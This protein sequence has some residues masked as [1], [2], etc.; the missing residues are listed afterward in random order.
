MQV[1]AEGRAAAAAV[2]SPSEACGALARQPNRRSLESFEGRR[3]QVSE[4][5]DATRR[6]GLSADPWSPVALGALFFLLYLATLC[7]GI[8]W[9]DSA[10]FVTA[11]VTLGIPH[12][13]GYPL[14]TLLAHAF[15]WLP[16]APALAV[17]GMSAVGGGLSVALLHCVIR[18]L[19]ASNGA[20][21]IGA[22]TLGASALFW[23]QA[24]IAEAYTPGLAM[25]LGAWLLLVRAVEEDRTGFAVAAAGLAGLGLGVHLG[26][27]TCG[28]GFV[29]L[30]LGEGPALQRVKRG[31]LAGGAALLG[32]AHFAYIPWRAAMEPALNFGAASNWK[33][34]LWLVSGGNYK[35]W[36]I[37][38]QAF[39]PRALHVGG[40]LYDQLLIAGVV[41]AAAGFVWLWRERRIHA[42]AMAAMMAGNLYWFFW[43]GV[44]DLEIFFLPTTVVLC[45]AVGLGAHALLLF[46]QR[47]SERAPSLPVRAMAAGLLCL[48]P[49][50]LAAGNYRTVDMSDFDEAERFAAA[51]VEG[52]PDG[53]IIVDY[54][55][56]GEWK[57]DAVFGMYVQK[58]LGQRNDVEVLKAPQPA[59]VIKL[60]REGR[61]VFAY[62]ASPPIHGFFGVMGSEPLLRIVGPSPGLAEHMGEA[63]ARRTAP[64]ARAH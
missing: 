3:F 26:I 57:F 47:L 53:A 25:M 11:A 18:R 16:I 45:A 40:L 2:Q 27:A 51:A 7:R 23:S 1:Y 60:L 39:G 59:A 52:L 14:Y 38:D 41:L 61:S 35:N 6:A 17:N 49:V 33:N 43:Y 46:A 29:I 8:Y 20:A 58:V 34:F 62:A 44:H 13:P 63:P 24:L 12:P 21:A 19:G 4:N 64:V 37:E 50:S 15:T 36:F 22:A 30:A 48:W 55:T 9:Y 56:P 32:L 10:E 42:V 31:A 5:Q 54:T 28:L